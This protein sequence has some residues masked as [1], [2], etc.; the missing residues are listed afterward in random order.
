MTIAT[1]EVMPATGPPTRHHAAPSSWELL[2]LYV[3]L[4]KHHFDLFLKGYAVYLAIVATVAGFVFRGEIEP[5]TR[6]A[7]LLLVALVSIAAVIAWSTAFFWAR[8]FGSQVQSLCR[9]L[10]IPSMPMFGVKAILVIADAGALIMFLGA[11]FFL[12]WWRV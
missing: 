4:Y 12:V 5:V 2:K 9:E 6:A 7:L 3:D 8:A 11:T 10:G 1:N